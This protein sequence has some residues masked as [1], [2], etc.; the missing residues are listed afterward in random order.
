[1]NE[2][3][4]SR[5]YYTV[6]VAACFVIP[7][8]TLIA[9]HAG[10]WIPGLVAGPQL[11]PITMLFVPLSAPVYFLTGGTT[12]VLIGILAIWRKKAASTVFST[13]I[14]AACVTFQVVALWALQLPL[15]TIVYRLV[16]ERGG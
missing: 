9:A 2:P 4:W 8:T 1:M 16:N 3:S 14:F 11:P 10:A 15:I 5:A 13:G 6:A 12:L 7:V